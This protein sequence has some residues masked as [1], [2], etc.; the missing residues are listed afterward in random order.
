MGSEGQ[1]E[2]K[3]VHSRQPGDGHDNE[4]A[5]DDDDDNEDGDDD[6]KTTRGWSHLS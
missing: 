4:Y 3:Q 6:E 1:P 2:D 5:D